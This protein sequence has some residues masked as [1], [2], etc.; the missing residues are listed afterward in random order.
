MR[1]YAKSTHHET[2]INNVDDN[3]LLFTDSNLPYL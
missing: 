2:I 1:C 3:V